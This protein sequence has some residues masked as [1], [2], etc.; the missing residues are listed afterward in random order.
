MALIHC[1]QCGKEISDTMSA[2]PYCGNMR[3]K[4]N[5]P[6]VQ[7]VSAVSKLKNKIP[8]KETFYSVFGVLCVFTGF[9]LFLPLIINI[10]IK[11]NHN[12]FF[13]MGEIGEIVLGTQITYN[14]FLS[15]LLFF[16]VG[17]GLAFFYCLITQKYLK[18]PFLCGVLFSFVFV[19]ICSIIN[20]C[21]FS[22]IKADTIPW[23]S[24]I[25]RYGFGMSSPDYLSNSI[26]YYGIV[27]P[28][29]FCFC[30]F[31][32]YKK[33]PL[34]GMIW[35][36]CYLIS[37][38]ILTTIVAF[39]SVSIDFGL[40]FTCTIWDIIPAILIAVLFVFLNRRKQLQK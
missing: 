39:I 4:N 16:I 40:I 18:K 27:I 8:M 21:Y 33:K 38:G 7:S 35:A 11:I 2:C 23:P 9:R 25:Q 30:C 17:V 26:A 19:V 12:W 15:V 20:F 14:S 1:E 29:M 5:V 28:L 6:V 32:A 22:G 37:C 3:Q 24:I 36:A 10:I 13:N 31:L 34:S